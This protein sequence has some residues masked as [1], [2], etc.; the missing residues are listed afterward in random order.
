MYKVLVTGVGAVIGYGIVRSLRKARPETV[1]IGMDIYPDAVGKQWCDHFEQSP[2]VA[3]PEYSGFL[4]EVIRRHGVDLVIPGIEQDVSY[5]ARESVQGTLGG[6]TARFVLNNPR[7]I[8]I[9]DD[10]WLTHLHLKQNG[11]P[12][13]ETRVE[14]E[15][16]DLAGVLGLPMLLKPR[17][18]YASK[19]IQL[20]RAQEDF[21]YWK[22]R[23]G[24]N[25]LVQQLIGDLEEEYTVGA[26]G[27]G[28]G[29]CV[30]PIILQRKLS[31][32]GATA[33]ARVRDLPELEQRVRRLVELFEPIGPT[34]F[35][36]RR[37]RGE[38][39][40]LEI[41]PRMSSSNSLRTSFG[42]NEAEMCIEYYLENKQP[43][44]PQIRSG[45]AVRY[46]EDLVVYDRSDF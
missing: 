20:I 43:S 18:S 36:F 17:R 42:Y 28:G 37:H 26:F 6:L 34:N 31:R 24:D 44:P 45:C 21:D 32:E 30:P 13:I 11:L 38:Y 8:P 29:K 40:L 35:Q 5:L 16:A 19:G 23:L 12:T 4:Q 25:F 22:A 3:D 2:L 39:L 15:F 27:L 9:A 46:L 1:V 33:K 41:N 7:L 10:K 14:G